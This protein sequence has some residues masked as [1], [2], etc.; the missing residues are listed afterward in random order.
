M[1]GRK[2]QPNNGK[3][4]IFNP[5]EVLKILHIK[6]AT[7]IWLYMIQTNQTI[8]K[9]E[10]IPFQKFSIGE[11]AKQI[12]LNEFALHTT[13]IIEKFESA[14]GDTIKLLIELFDGHRVETVIMKHHK[15]TS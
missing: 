7:K 5:Q 6:N 9:L 14:R 2:R 10:D 8:S 15:R 4:S 1:S 13:K 12:L 11:N 3:K